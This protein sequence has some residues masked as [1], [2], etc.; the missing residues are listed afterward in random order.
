MSNNIS[1]AKLT[2]L[3]GEIEAELVIGLLE[4]HDIPT[5]KV[6]PGATQYVKVYMGTA[7]GV[8]IHVP[9]EQLEIAKKILR[10]LED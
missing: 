6:Y 2:S 8:E 4:T 10:E 1:W 5:R 3:S 9:K 7:V